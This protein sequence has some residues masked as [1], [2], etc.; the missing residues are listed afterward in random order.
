MLETRV[1][2]TYSLNIYII[3]ISLI[4]ADVL[5][6]YARDKGLARDKYYVDVQGI[7]WLNLVSNIGHKDISCNERE[8]NKI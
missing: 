6:A 1:Q 2:P 5:V 4:T 8:I 3:F 7:G